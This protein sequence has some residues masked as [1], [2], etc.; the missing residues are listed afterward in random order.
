[1]GM[2]PLTDSDVR[3]AAKVMRGL[4]IPSVGSLRLAPCQT[5]GATAILAAAA[6]DA[7][8]NVTRLAFPEGTCSLADM[9]ASFPRVTEVVVTWA[10]MVGVSRDTFPA[11][12]RL[13][14]A[15]AIGDPAPNSIFATQRVKTVVSR[16]RETLRHLNVSCTK[17]LF[18]SELAGMLH[19]LVSLDMSHCS[20]HSSGA[21]ERLASLPAQLTE[22]DLSFS[23]ALDSAEA[24][25]DALAG[26]RWMRSLR[27]L[28]LRGVCCRHFD[29]RGVPSPLGLAGTGLARLLSLADM[30]NLETLDLGCTR[31]SCDTE[32]LSVFAALRSA[33]EEGRMPS[34]QEL[35]L[36][37]TMYSAFPKRELEIIAGL[38]FPRLHTLNLG[39]NSLGFFDA[40]FAAAARALATAVPALRILFVSDCSLRDGAVLAPEVAPGGALRPL[41]LLDL[42]DNRLD[43]A[44]L[45]WTLAAARGGGPTVLWAG[46]PCGTPL[47]FRPLADRLAEGPL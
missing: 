42:S 31:S 47:A 16:H 43:A 17:C 2:R 5:P 28:T 35:D 25:I 18:T 19:N 1:M 27:S 41:D 4:H 6:A 11:L 3:A 37:D 39:S 30:P 45:V 24:E 21:L 44:A 13:S 14:V 29:G 9:A 36:S 33:A 40:Q 46:N 34:L 15:W 10:E 23:L 22:L 20:L 12:E 8:P 7:F 32:E 38:A 26:A